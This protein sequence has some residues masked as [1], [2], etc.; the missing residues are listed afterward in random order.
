MFK[1][2]C[3][4][5]FQRA[6]KDVHK[7][8]QKMETPTTKKMDHVWDGLYPVVVVVAAAAAVFF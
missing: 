6:E 2:Q 1:R 3:I 4:N 7:Q 8:Q 5:T